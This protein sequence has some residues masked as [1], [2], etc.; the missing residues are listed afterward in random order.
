MQVNKCAAWS[1]PKTGFSSNPDEGYRPGMDITWGGSSVAN[2][3]SCLELSNCRVDAHTDKTG[4]CCLS[5]QPGKG[6]CRMLIQL[7]IRQIRE[8]KIYGHCW[9][10]LPDVKG[11]GTW[12]CPL[13]PFNTQDMLTDSYQQL[14]AQP[15][16]YRSD[17]QL[18][19]AEWTN[20]FLKRRTAVLFAIC[21]PH[22][23]IQS[24][25]KFY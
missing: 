6:D 18:T 16:L 7:R 15:G 1:L 10:W 12:W 9:R 20:C 3:V 24:E 13:H 5:L 11:V 19:A 21:L 14:A 2:K 22:K 23:R 8:A 17:T 25:I 4:H